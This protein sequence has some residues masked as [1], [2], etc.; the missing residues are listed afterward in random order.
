[1]ATHLGLFLKFK[2]FL[3]FYCY[4]CVKLNQQQS[5][6]KIKKEKPVVKYNKN[7]KRPKIVVKTLSCT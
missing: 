5:N 4:R 1:M 3:K 6:K 7:S 2:A